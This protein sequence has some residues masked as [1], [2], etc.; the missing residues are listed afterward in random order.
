M[1]PKARS[2]CRKIRSWVSGRLKAPLFD[3]SEKM[4]F[5]EG[6]LESGSS[7][8]SSEEASSAA[9]RSVKNW[10][11]AEELPCRRSCIAARIGRHSKI[12]V[13]GRLSLQCWIQSSAACLTWPTQSLSRSRMNT[14][15]E[16]SRVSAS[17]NTA[18]SRLQPLADNVLSFHPAWPSVLKSCP[19]E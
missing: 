15:A 7:R 12:W 5:R 1:T 2:G 4:S 6:A 9:S 14:R 8:R 19:S 3:K 18:F 16:A 13:I 10:T 11:N 17:F